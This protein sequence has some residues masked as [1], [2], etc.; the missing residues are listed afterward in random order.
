M[1][2]IE[3]LF[4][5]GAATPERAAFGFCE[6]TSAPARELTWGALCERVAATAQALEQRGLA[7]RACLLLYPTE[8]EFIVA[9]LACLAARVIPAPVS[10]GRSNN[11]SGERLRAIA[12]D[13]QAA[14]ILLPQRTHGAAWLD[15]MLAESPLQVV[16]TEEL[17]ACDAP[18][19]WCP[20]ALQS[21]DVAFL[22]YTSGSTGTPKGVVVT[23]GNL[24]ANAEAVRVGFSIDAT[25][26]LVCWLPHYHDL[27]L[28]G[29]L[30]Q[31]VV[32]GAYCLLIPP[33][34]LVRNPIG[35]LQVISRHRATV[36]MA[37]NFAFGLCAARATPAAVQGLDLRSLKTLINA[38]EPVR[39][40][41]MAAFSEAFAPAGFDPQAFRV[42][43][44]LAEATLVATSGHHRR[45]VSSLT[46]DRELLKAGRLVLCAPEAA[47]SRT[48]VSCG[49]P[50]G[51]IEVVIA[52]PTTGEALPSG[53]IGEVWLRG[54][55]ICHGFWQREAESR[56]VF[57][58]TTRDGRGGCL[59]TGDL[60]TVVDGEL[61][62][63]GRSKEL[64]LVR[65]SNHYPQD[66]EHTA[67][68]A[69][70]AFRA[71]GGAA[72][73]DDDEGSER[74]TIV[75]EIEH[76][77]IKQPHYEEWAFRLRT[78]VFE[79]HGI[80]VADVV[81]VRPFSVPKT[82]SGKTQRRLCRDLLRSGRLE[83][84]NAAAAEDRSASA[85]AAL[86]DLASRRLN[87]RLMDER[88]AMSPLLILELGKRGLLGLERPE[89]E[90]GLGLSVAEALSVVEQAAAIDLSLANF[91]T[92]Q[93][94]LV[95]KALAEARP[96]HPILPRLA[97]GR[98]L[99]AFAMTEPGAGSN[100]RGIRTVARPLGP[101][102]W[103]IDGEKIWIGNA[104]WSSAMLVF[105]MRLDERGAPLGV[106][107][108]LVPSDAPGVHVQDEHL[109]MGLR[110]MVQNT[111][112]LQGV[113]VTQDQLIGPLDRGMDVAQSAMRHARL[114][115]AAGAVGG[116][117]RA[118]QLMARYAA[119]RN[120][121]SQRLLSLPAVNARVAHAACLAELG[122]VVVNAIATRLDAGER[123]ADELYAAIKVIGPESLWHVLDDLVQLLGGR[124]YIESNQVPQM[125]RDARVLRIFEGPTETMQAFLGSAVRAR[126]DAVLSFIAKDLRGGDAARALEQLLR[127]SEAAFRQLAPAHLG[128]AHL[129]LGEV[130]TA[131]VMAAA[132]NAVAPAAL[133]IDRGPACERLANALVDAR[134]RLTQ[135]LQG[136]APTD[137]AI[138]C[139]LA[140]GYA[141]R[142][143]EITAAPHEEITRLDELLRPATAE[144]LDGGTE[145]SD[146]HTP[147]APQAPDTA[148]VEMPF[149]TPL[150]HDPHRASHA[151]AYAG[152]LRQLTHQIFGRPPTS[153][154]IA[155]ADIGLDSMSAAELAFEMDKATG[156]ELEPTIF[157]LYPTIAKLSDHLAARAGE[158][159]DD[160]PVPMAQ[161]GSPAL[162]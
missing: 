147:G 141:E 111:V 91:I 30:L 128:A 109:T 158:A 137:P 73:L 81:F 145:P 80:A 90:G 4:A 68:Q 108:F 41:T 149:S 72:F 102:R 99:G 105:A 124:G 1:N 9:F 28:I 110:S 107:G 57:G 20:P 70:E 2:L 19:S 112:R 42:A 67:Q 45:G 154:H 37:P 43:Y 47:H 131:T 22:Q 61:Y 49:V 33:V 3:H 75:Q 71:T 138:L 94:A 79:E 31:T 101:D 162:Q 32:A 8:L 155:F 56:E 156:L 97:S 127:D 65:G 51:D 118:V 148:P 64:I 40:D 106:S 55:S 160:S 76:G 119:R 7:G 11:S 25:S 12:R 92:L 36:S 88:R 139:A 48:L 35:W 93:N 89:V 121:A 130:V 153:D 59:R 44:G 85:R 14:A 26:R 133:R 87:F 157:W 17:Q 39:E 136:Q 96:S 62:I 134:A 129:A 120:M 122:A 78:R 52:D 143:G 125:L 123:V 13:C 38:A 146:A 100:V 53:R 150:P 151:E 114:Y 86:R 144:G 50:C 82:S 117:R 34:S 115:I 113:I 23:H 10:Q 66:I 54:T 132:L 98:D 15:E 152:Q 126:P 142:L 74:L 6:T 69:C 58:V 16:A 159:K 46:V 24:I 103:A 140:D 21:D 63:T 104:G 60:G 135:A 161:E 29:N 116:M 83:R 84:L 95:I 18:A 77:A 5:H 27:G